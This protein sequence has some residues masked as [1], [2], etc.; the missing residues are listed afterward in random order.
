MSEKLADLLD[1]ELAWQRVRTDIPER[2][3]VRHPYELSLIELDLEGWLCSLR[4]NIRSNSYSPK[5]M[6]VCDVPKGNGLIRPGGH[7]SMDDRVIYAAC[8]GACFPQIHQALSWAQ[9]TIDFSYRLPA[10]L[11]TPGW[12]RSQFGGWR[13]FR[14]R[15]LSKIAEGVSYVVMTDI[16]GYYENVDIFLLISDLKQMGAPIEAVD[17]LSTCLNRWSQ[18]RGRGIPQGHSPSDILGKLYL[19]S[20]DHNLQTMGYTHYRYV[21][22][23]R[24]F[25]HDLVEA[26]KALIDLNRLLRER[27]LSLQSAKSQILRADKAREKIEGVVPA[28]NAVRQ[29][30]IE[31]AR[32]L[33]GLADSYISMPEAEEILCISDPDEA[34]V[35][36]IRETYQ[37]YFVDSTD[38][39]FDNTLFHFLLNRLGRFKDR[40]AVDHCKNLFERHPEETRY[41]LRYFSQVEAVEETEESIIEFLDSEDAIYT[42]QIFQMIEWYNGIHRDP[43][44]GLLSIV[45]RLAFD[46]SQPAYLRSVCRKF[47]GGF[48]LVA[49]LERLQ[50]SYPE[51]SSSLE[52]SEIICSLNRMEKG[53]RNS[54][55]SSVMNDGELNRRATD[56]VK[57]GEL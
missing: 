5:P 31:N 11:D 34:P 37:T 1:L 12:L 32:S 25:C 51:A 27:G 36:L 15:S 45:R 44:D 46:N 7:I 52:Q 57:T 14:T 43:S 38:D 13:D 6:V 17:Q 24:F 40:F 56:L 33:S 28:I 2:V 8:V 48:G 3:F 42:Y 39:Q 9:G 54:F 16:S 20:I 21:D 30:L 41:I 50:H 10:T 19:N 23:F 55:L 22:D 35:G 47:L 49:D 26:K 4:E 53:R 18:V 29:E